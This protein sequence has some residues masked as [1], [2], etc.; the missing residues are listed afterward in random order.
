MSQIESGQP[1]YDQTF[2][3]LDLA[4]LSLQA[5]EF[6]DCEFNGCIFT[7]ASLTSCRW[8]DCTFRDC[9]LSLAD[10]TGSAFSGVNF[11]DC[12]LVGVNWAQADWN[13]PRLD[14][15]L[16][17]KACSLNHS[18]FIGLKLHQAK[19]IDCQAANLDFR[20]ADLRQADFS[21]SDLTDS[22]FGDTDLRKT[23]FRQARNYSLSPLDNKLKGALFSLPEAMSLL[24]HLDIHLD[25]E[26]D[27][28]IER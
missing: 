26:W 5:T 2:S 21:G 14:N 8:V 3:G 1:Y 10:L 9:D 13:H 20:G 15:R 4:G 19:I 18:T 6:N 7:E 12:K 28:G 24:Y 17:F 11:E 27:R 25:G 22:L 16:N 23:D